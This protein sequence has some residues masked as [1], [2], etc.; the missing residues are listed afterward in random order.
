VTQ[1]VVSP[2]ILKRGNEETVGQLGTPFPTPD[3]NSAQLLAFT[4]NLKHTDGILR[5]EAAKLAGR[6]C[7]APLAAGG[8]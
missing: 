8:L 5:G 4:L 1:A 2:P 7:V 3:P 6:E